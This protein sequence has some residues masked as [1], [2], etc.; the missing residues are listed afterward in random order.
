MT[1]YQP[2]PVVFEGVDVHGG[3]SVKRYVI[4]LPGETIDSDRFAPALPLA[5]EALPQPATAP[6]R[7]GAA[8]LIEHQG[9]G[10]DYLVLAWWDRE[11]EL[12][13]RVWVRDGG[14]W[15]PAKGSE[16]ICV[17]DLGVLWS[18]RQAW[19]RH[20]LGADDPD[21]SSWRAD[22]APDRV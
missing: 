19:V 18:E 15:R 16:S 12:P 17:W 11:N 13:I 8:V 9:A 10:A 3:W 7:A 1:P 4:H 22:I 14:A 5:F 21:L 20:R 6:G 2:R